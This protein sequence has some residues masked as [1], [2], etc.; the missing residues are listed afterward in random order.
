[1]IDLN[2]ASKR[3]RPYRWVEIAIIIAIGFV[4]ACLLIPTIQVA[5]WVG[6]RDVE[7]TIQVVDSDTHQPIPGA[8]VHQFDSEARKQCHQISDAAGQ[9]QFVENLLCS[10]KS[11]LFVNTMSVR[12]PERLIWAE[13]IGYLRSDQMSFFDFRQMVRHHKRSSELTI[14]IELKKQSTRE[15]E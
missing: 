6:S 1:M 14:T 13:A 15:F 5:V 4:I 12:L 3:S 8:K 10:G 9:V 7:F 2:S 11:G